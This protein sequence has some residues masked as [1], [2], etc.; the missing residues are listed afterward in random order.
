MEGVII[1]AD[2]EL[3]SLEF[4]QGIYKGLVQYNK[5]PVLGLNNLDLTKSSILSINNIKALILDY[6]FKEK[7][8]DD[9]LPDIERKASEILEDDDLHIFSLI[10]I[11]SQ[12]ELENTEFGTNLKAKY[13][14][15][16]VKFRLKSSDAKKVKD[17][18][19]SILTDIENWDREH[20]HLTVPNIWN[21]SLGQAIQSIF[22]SLD[23]ADH[24]WIKDLFYSS[25]RK[26]SKIGKVVEVEVEPTIQVINLFQHLLSEK[27][28]QN[29][30]LRDSINQYSIDNFKNKTTPESYANL[31]Q[32]LYF[33]KT[34]VTDEIMTGDIFEISKNNYAILISPECDITF[35]KT[36]DLQM[37]FL[38][39]K[40]DD[41]DTY[42][43]NHFKT[44]Q[45]KQKAFNQVKDRIHVLPSFPFDDNT[46]NKSAFIDF[47]ISLNLIKGS[48]LKLDHRKFK[49]NSPY[50]QQL[51]QR[52]LSYIGRV[53]V[54]AI[55]NSM[56]EY[57]LKKN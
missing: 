34:P 24:Y 45:E 7:S 27:L 23:K 46:K 6:T 22:H 54:P 36:K 43:E 40:K 3:N 39:F 51:R 15:N 48:E 37:E 56:V 57:N 47:R 30:S 9:D 18:Y 25:V 5:F 31:F 26:K 20:P 28:I 21:K 14:N 17:E 35:L 1:F 19:E 13:G 4:M 41:F 10:Y 55:P 8:E 50:I 38:C 16:S 33:T 29:K 44:E 49:L 42:I 53:G 2:D 52:Y 32:R 12:E 11:Y